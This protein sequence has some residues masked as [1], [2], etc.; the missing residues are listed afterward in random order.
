MT[1]LITI[2]VIFAV[3]VTNLSIIAL[4]Y[5]HKAKKK[6][7]LD[8]WA[9]SNWETALYEFLFKNQDEN[10]IA[11]KFGI[12]STKYVAACNMAEQDIK[13][14]NV[15][16]DKLLGLI[17]FFISI[18]TLFIFEN[19]LIC[20]SGTFLGLFVSSKTTMKAER[21]AKTKRLQ[22]TKELPRFLD[23]LYTALRLNLPVIQAIEITADSLSDTLLGKEFKRTLSSVKLGSE[24]WQAMLEFVA[25]KYNIETFTDF[26]IDLVTA[27]N[28]GSSIAETVN[29]KSRE[30]KQYSL[31]N[32][33][34]R[35]SKMTST[36]LFPILVFKIIPILAL[37]CVPVIIQLN[38]GGF[39]I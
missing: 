17:L 9:F 18:S 34:E 16:I 26:V 39:G 36:I 10:D 30:I 8:L 31:L 19:L 25:N 5:A 29:Q 23:L 2:F 24:S 4:S 27:Y 20:I 15:I 12:N 7:E 28:T 35:A 33:K 13:L 11:R 6:N 14:K 32:A 1:A 22:L 38:N 37:L 3:F 21:K